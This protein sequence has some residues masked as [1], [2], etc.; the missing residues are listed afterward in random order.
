MM[1]K[2]E[3]WPACLDCVWRELKTD[4]VVASD[5]CRDVE[6]CRKAPVCRRIEGQEMIGGTVDLPALRAVVAE[7]DE[8]EML[9]EDVEGRDVGN[10]A[11]RLRAALRVG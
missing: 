11:R 10:F 5:G 4:R 1:N 6:T 7:M 3:I 9:R 8:Y 2:L